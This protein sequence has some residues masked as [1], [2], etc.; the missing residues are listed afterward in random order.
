MTEDWS[1]L[2][3]KVPSTIKDE[4]VRYCNT[5]TSHNGVNNTCIL[6]NSRSLLSSLDQ[7]NVCTATSVRTFDFSTLHTSIPPD[8][9]KWR[10]C[11]HVHNAFRKKDGSVRYTHIKVT[12]A[13]SFFTHHINGS[14]NSMYTADNIWKTIEFLL[15]N[16]LCSLEAI[17]SDDWNSNG[18]Q[19]CFIT[20]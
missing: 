5:K 6:K 1:Y 11:N 16:I 3:T 19:L 17:L 9:L 14:E 15:D 13:K 2:L 8:L 4:L 12:R 7:L 10:I 20:C 18:N